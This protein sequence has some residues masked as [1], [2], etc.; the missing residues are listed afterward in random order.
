M[1]ASPPPHCSRGAAITRIG[2]LLESMP[3]LPWQVRVLA[4]RTVQHAAATSDHL[5][6]LADGLEE[7]REYYRGQ[8]QERPALAVAAVADE[9]RRAAPAFAV[10]LQPPDLLRG[11][12]RS[13]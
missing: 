3:G 1:S 2:T 8:E 12:R 11:E 4:R 6:V 7:I 9:L 5:L 10:G 13:G